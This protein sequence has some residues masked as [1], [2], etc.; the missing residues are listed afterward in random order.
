ME[1]AR[2]YKYGRI[3]G[4]TRA[5]K[6]LQVTRQHLWLV[7]TGQRESQPLLRRY[8]KLTD[9]QGK[10]TGRVMPQAN[11]HPAKAA[12]PTQEAPHE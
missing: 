7:L 1:K 8:L 9:R 3:P 5:A 4:I 12:K 11:F 2:I 10:A 6:E